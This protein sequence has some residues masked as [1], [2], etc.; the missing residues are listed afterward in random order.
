MQM[1]GHS[2][3]LPL[4]QGL[5]SQGVNE[6]MGGGGVQTGDVARIFLKPWLS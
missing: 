2:N 4:R 1:S 3:H 5:K 6:E